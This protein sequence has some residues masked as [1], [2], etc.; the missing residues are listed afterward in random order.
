[1]KKSRINFNLVLTLVIYSSVACTPSVSPSVVS[2]SSS[3]NAPNPS[4]SQQNPELEIAI[5]PWVSS[6]EQQDK[7]Q[8]L[9]EY[10][11]Q[12]L[13]QPVKIQLTKDYETAVNLLVKG[14]VKVAYLGPL[15]YI[16]AKQRNPNLEPIVAHIEK[17]TGRP[18]YTSVIVVNSQ[19][20]I[21]TLEDI[22][23]KRFSFVSPSSTSGF[24]FPSAKFKKLGMKPDRD[25]SEVQ[26]AGGHDKN[27][28][29]LAEGKVDAIAVNKSAYIEAVQQNLLPENQYKTIWESQPIPNSPFVISSSLPS[30]L[31]TKLQRALINAPE[32]LLNVGGITATGYTVVQD[33]DYEP[34]RKLQTFL[35]K[36]TQNP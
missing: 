36:P 13:H 8:Q 24:L 27:I 29:A 31:K 16:Q 33:E 17:T 7:I 5:I 4:N 18:W 12:E 34:I 19:A 32:G 6:T 23:G 21:I 9:E 11:K 14:E 20:G 28:I 2:P 1:M 30:E 15:S 22:K 3:T 25:F 10:L 35:E 26:Y